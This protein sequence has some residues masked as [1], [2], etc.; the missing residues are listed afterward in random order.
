ME[1]V[2]NIIERG[3]QTENNKD[4]IINCFPIFKDNILR[5]LIQES[6]QQREELPNIDL[7]SEIFQKFMSIM[8]EN[9][10]QKFNEE[11]LNLFINKN[12][13]DSMDIDSDIEF[14]PLNVNKLILIYVS[15]RK[16]KCITNITLL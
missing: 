10:N 15:K 1:S 8:D 11:I 16:K 7:I 4:I 13:T 12:M 9:Q 5:I 6:V 2:K 3:I 14:N